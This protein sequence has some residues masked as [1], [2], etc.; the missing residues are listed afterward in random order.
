VRHLSVCRQE[1]CCATLSH[2][3]LFNILQIRPSDSYALRKKVIQVRTIVDDELGYVASDSDT[4]LR[5]A[6]LYI[7]KRRV[8][9]LVTAEVIEKGYA[10]QNNFERS[11]HP[12]KAMIGIHH[13]WVHSKFRKQGIAT[14]L[15]DAVRGKMVFGLVVPPERLAFSSPTEAGV[16]FARRYVNHA[17]HG[18]SSKDVLVYECT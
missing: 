5:S 12:Q 3:I 4:A 18:E 7:R 16:K 2:A 6:Y 15:I 17:S 11:K 13:M 9:G 1:P 14:R 10:L 8:V